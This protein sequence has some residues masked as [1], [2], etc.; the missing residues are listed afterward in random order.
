M[1]TSYNPC[2]SRFCRDCFT[3]IATSI[4][5][6]QCTFEKEDFTLHAGKFFPD[7]AMK[8][9]LNNQKA[10]C[11]TW[12][13]PWKGKFKEY[14]KHVLVCEYKKIKCECGVEIFKLDFNEHQK[15]HCSLR[16]IPCNYCEEQIT[17]RDI[18]QHLNIC[19]RYP[20][21]CPN[22]CGQNNRRENVEEH[23]DPNTGTCP[24]KPC[25]FGCTERGSGHDVRDVHNHAVILLDMV[26]ALQ[27][28]VHKN[29]GSNAEVEALQQKLGELEK[30]I[31]EIQKRLHPNN[32]NENRESGRPTPQMQDEREARAGQREISG[33]FRSEAVAVAAC[34]VT[35]NPTQLYPRIT[36]TP[37]QINNKHSASNSLSVEVMTEKQILLEGLA[38]VLNREVEKLITDQ[39]NAERQNTLNKDV[40]GQLKDRITS[41]E[42]SM[43]LKDITLT[44]QDLRIRELETTS[45]NGTLIWPIADFKRKRQEAINGRTPS[46]YSTPF[47]T[48]RAG[49][50]ICL[51]LY[52]NG[53]AWGREPISLS[54]L[55]S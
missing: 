11:Q 48:S 55:S 51:R 20:V 5:C 26:T 19:R 12:A 10:Q 31:E 6:P 49:Y 17:A 16:Q 23:I 7:P 29:E 39:A 34:T 3:S 14:V 22:G 41:L 46:I 35:Q 28:T 40:I 8:R 25:P 33:S 42:R 13:C 54:S 27:T 9:E 52:L 37:G 21:S 53:M 44:E 18:G 2:L 1:L 50:K 43:T 45:F 30:K 15:K 24:N 38:A 32:L 47:Y 4:K 36:P